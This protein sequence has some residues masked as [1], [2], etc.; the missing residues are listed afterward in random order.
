MSSANHIRLWIFASFGVALIVIA[1][2]WVSA[3]A[4]S[5]GMAVREEARERRQ[6]SDAVDEVYVNLLDAE[7]GQRGYLLTMDRAYLLPYQRASSQPDPSAKLLDLVRKNDDIRPVAEHLVRELAAKRAELAETLLLADTQGVDQA[8]RMLNAG[9]GAALSNSIRGDLEKIAHATDITRARYTERITHKLVLARAVVLSGTL[10]A[11]ALAVGVNLILMRALREREAA[12][13]VVEQQSEQ[14]RLQTETLMRHER[15]LA[16]Q[17]ARQQ[18]L[19]SALQRSNEELD[20]FAYATSHDLKAPLRGI[21]NLATFIEEDLGDHATQEVRQNLGLLRSRARRLESLIEGI[22]AYSRAGRVR[23]TLERVDTRALMREVI[24]LIAPPG[25]CDI[26]VVGDMPTIETERVPLQQVFMNLVQNA[27]KHG[28][29]EGRGRVE[30]SARAQPGGWLFSVR[31]FGAG[32]PAEFHA[33]IFT[34]FQ[35]LAPRDQVEGTGIGLAVVKK[36]VETRGGAVHL[37]SA[38]GAGARFDFTW[39]IPSSI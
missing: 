23:A 35:T 15:Q 5:S 19:A 37:E 28:C 6:I 4:L 17:L 27:V 21:M 14:L 32:I 20:Q 24:E 9:R 34:V 26:A 18:E 7:T 30:V 16:D 13:L 3:G 25:G 38:P 33:R 36:L 39:P 10:L 31:D 2:G 8:I 1:T 12:Q 11:F 22:L 29:K